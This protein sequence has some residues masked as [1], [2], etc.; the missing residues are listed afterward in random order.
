MRFYFDIEEWEFQEEDGLNFQETIM[1]RVASELAM[2][3]W[4]EATDPDG[5]YSEVKNHINEIIKLRQNEIVEAVIE[6]VADKIAPKKALVEFTPKARELAALDKDNV[7]YFEEMI[8]KAI[9]K[10]FAK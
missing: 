9:A 6:R 1:N 7:T 4:N 5:W 8:D 10:R 2:Q 3:V